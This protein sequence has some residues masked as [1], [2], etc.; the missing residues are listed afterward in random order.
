MQ[1]VSHI[2]LFKKD[3]YVFDRVCVCVCV[4]GTDRQSGP[5]G[6]YLGSNA[7]HPER[8]C[9]SNLL[10]SGRNAE[11]IAAGRHGDGT[12]PRSIFSPFLLFLLSAFPSGPARRYPSLLRSFATGLVLLPFLTN[13]SNDVFCRAFCHINNSVS[14]SILSSCH[15]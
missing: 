2:D 6:L 1:F 13:V 8:L 14:R 11:R 9:S 10:F 3:V 7:A 12:W 4:C 15:Y 5:V